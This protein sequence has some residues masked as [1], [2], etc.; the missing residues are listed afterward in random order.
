[1][2]P[3]QLRLCGGGEDAGEAGTLAVHSLRQKLHLDLFTGKFPPRH[4]DT[5]GIAIPGEGTDMKCNT[6]AAGGSTV[7]GFAEFAAGIE[8]KGVTHGK[9]SQIKE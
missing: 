9:P 8:Y 3:E 6:A 7:G 1:M 2:I 5:A 4:Q